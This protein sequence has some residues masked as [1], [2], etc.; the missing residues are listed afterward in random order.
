[1]NIFGPV[2]IGGVVA[3]HIE[4]FG[5]DHENSIQTWGYFIYAFGAWEGCKSIIFEYYLLLKFAND[6]SLHDD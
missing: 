3:L 1:M 6:S 4:L 2:Y 5:G